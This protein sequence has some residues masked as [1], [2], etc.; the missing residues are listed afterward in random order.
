MNVHD[1]ES[2]QLA[3][4]PFIQRVLLIH[5]FIEI[6]QNESFPTMKN[7]SAVG[8]G[9]SAP[10]P[11]PCRRI[12]D[13]PVFRPGR[14]RWLSMPPSPPGEGHGQG[15]GDAPEPPGRRRR[16]LGGTAGAFSLSRISR[17]GSPVFRPGR[18]KWLSMP[19]STSGGAWTGGA[20]TAPSHRVVY[21][22]LDPVSGVRLIGGS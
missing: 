6:I 21:L 17:T 7:P 10:P 2:P 14:I 22:A 9:G 4:M 18:I 19:P 12:R 3:N 20:M 5:V 11:S 1:W 16:L 8:A 13:P 15:S